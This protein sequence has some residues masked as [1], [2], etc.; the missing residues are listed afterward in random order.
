MVRGPIPRAIVNS[1]TKTPTIPKDW[2]AVA[3][4][5]L[6]GHGVQVSSSPATRTAAISNSALPADPWR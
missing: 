3:A 6:Q 1:P 5:R 2:A 4:R